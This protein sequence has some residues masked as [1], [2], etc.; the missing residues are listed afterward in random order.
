MVHSFDTL[1]DFIASTQIE[2]EFSQRQ[3]EIR[4]FE[5]RPNKVFFWFCFF[6]FLEQKSITSF[7][8]TLVKIIDLWI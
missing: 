8:V 5:W 7:G 1:D 4:S 3:F 6:F 2:L